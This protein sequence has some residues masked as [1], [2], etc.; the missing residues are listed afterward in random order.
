MYMDVVKDIQ[1]LEEEMEQLK[2]QARAQAKEAEGAVEKEGRA[3]LAEARAAIRQAD[4]NSAAACDADR[5]AGMRETT[6]SPS[7]FV[8]VAYLRRLTSSIPD[9]DVSAV[10]CRWRHAWRRVSME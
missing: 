3:A 10:T 6:C 5:V 8:P 1:R 9:R 7:A 4:E 2:L